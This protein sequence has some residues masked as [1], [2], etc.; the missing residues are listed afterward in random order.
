MPLFA[1]TQH[2]SV[3]LLGQPSKAL[4][5]ILKDQTSRQGIKYIGPLPAFKPQLVGAFTGGE[6]GEALVPEKNG[7]TDRLIDV[8][9][10]L[11]NGLT[12]RALTA[13]H[14]ERKPDDHGTRF[15]LIE[16][17][18]KCRQVLFQAVSAQRDQSCRQSPLGIAAGQPN[19]RFRDV[20]RQQTLPAAMGR[21]HRIMEV[22]KVA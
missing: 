11:A 7:Q 17:V 20:E 12:A 13:V 21:R 3:R 4:D 19:D 15:A 18:P 1:E 9:R 22:L 10:K 16:P 2:L 14:I 5:C 6:G 8:V